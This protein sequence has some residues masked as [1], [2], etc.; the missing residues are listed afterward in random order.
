M[1]WKRLQQKPLP[2]LSGLAVFLS[3]L[4]DFQEAATKVSEITPLIEAFLPL[5]AV[6]GVTYFGLQSV[7]H[8]WSLRP[9]A[10]FGQLY[11]QISGLRN[12]VGALHEADSVPSGTTQL[13]GALHEMAYALSRFGIRCPKVKL[14]HNYAFAW[15]S[16]LTVLAPL[17]QHSHLRK[18]RKLRLDP[19]AKAA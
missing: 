6:G 18:A 2:S 3:L 19:P 11:P 17:A 13:L 8:I 1:S 9:S 14:D 7:A 12:A 4:L 16:F 15:F 5:V 10:K